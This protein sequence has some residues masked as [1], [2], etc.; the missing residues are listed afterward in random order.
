MKNIVANVPLLALEWDRHSINVTTNPNTEIDH[1]S[2]TVVSIRPTTKSGSSGIQTHY[3]PLRSGQ[4]YQIR[5]V[6]HTTKSRS[7]F[8]WGMTKE[9]DLL[10]KRNTFIKSYE[11]RTHDT[12]FTF[13]YCG[14]EDVCAKFGI[15]FD[16][17]DPKRDVLKIT[18]LEI[19]CQG[20]CNIDFS[21][22]C[23]GE[24]GRPGV[25]GCVGKNGEPGRPGKKGV[26]GK[27]SPGRPG[28]RG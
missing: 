12:T 28:C 15:F 10:F 2:S 18:E 27:G 16:H 24:K 7:A 23:P 13:C 22:G 17:P 1:S 21:Q 9:G 19:D 3:I 20:P 5:V 25:P 26:P 8:L 14:E 6:G 11:S 4:Q